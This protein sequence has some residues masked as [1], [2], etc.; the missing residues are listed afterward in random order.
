MSHVQQFSYSDSVISRPGGDSEV[1][2]AYSE[3]V[4]EM[5]VKKKTVTKKQ[6]K[7]LDATK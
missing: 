7:K 5:P 2:Q 1:E 3:S 4:I 6:S